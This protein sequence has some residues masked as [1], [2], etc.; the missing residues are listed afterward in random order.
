MRPGSAGRRA[1]QVVGS[2]CV[3]EEQQGHAEWRSDSKIEDKDPKMILLKF[4]GW[5]QTQDTV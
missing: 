2:K 3:D 4:I 1:F 5:K